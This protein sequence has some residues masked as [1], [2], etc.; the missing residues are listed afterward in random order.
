MAA[1]SA[2]AQLVTNENYMATSH[3]EW[4][5]YSMCMLSIVWALIQTI[6]LTRMNM[7]PAKVRSQFG[8]GV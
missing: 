7:D 8:M 3:S 5:V 2:A 6:L 4:I 1:A